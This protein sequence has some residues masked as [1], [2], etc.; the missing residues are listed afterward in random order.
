MAKQTDVNEEEDWN[1]KQTLK[2][3]V[4][5]TVGRTC[6][7][8]G[9]ELGVSFNKQVIA[10]LSE[11]T[12]KQITVYAKDLEAFAKHARRTTINADDVKLLVRRNPDLANHVK[13]MAK[14][15]EK[16]KDKEKKK[17]ARKRKISEAGPS[18]DDANTEDVQET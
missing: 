4:H 12:M 10:A 5:Y 18:K 13:E 16:S 14:G 8:V 3:A 11:L 9:S 1:H 2:A 7:E 17:R 6:E 15:I